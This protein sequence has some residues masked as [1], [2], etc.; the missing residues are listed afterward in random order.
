MKRIIALTMAMVMM[1]AMFAGCNTKPKD[2]PKT[3]DPKQ[4]VET[5]PEDIRLLAMSSTEKE[6]NVMRDQL[7]KAGFNVI[8]NIQPDYGSYTVVR[9]AGEYDLMITGWTTVTG[10][11]DYAV[12]SVFQTGGDYN[13]QPVEDKKIDEL[14]DKAGTETPEEYAN[15]YK[16]LEDVLVKENAY[17]IPMFSSLRIQ[18][19]DKAILD[20]SS[21]RQPKSRSN[22]WEK[23]SYVDT[24]LNATR[25]L[26][27]AQ[28]MSTLTS[29]WPIK[30]ND[31]SVNTLNT[32]IYV[33]L[34]N[35]TDE[36]DIEAAGSLSHNYAIG[37]GNETYYFL[38]RDDINF[39]KVEN[40]KAVDTGVRVGGE[41]VV[42]TL[43]NAK[44]K[45][46]APDHRTYTLHSSMEKI[47]VL[48]DVEELKTIKESGKTTTV[49][50]ALE[51]GAPAK[52]SSL[53]AAKTSVDNKAGKYQVIKITTNKPFPQVLNFLAHQSAGITCKEQV[54]KVNEGLDVAKYDPKTDV[55]YGDQSTVTEGPTYNNTLWMSGPYAMTY[56][57]DYEVAFEKNP[58][59]MVGTENEPKIQSI[60]YKFI[61]DN[62]STLSAFRA[63][64]IDM[65]GVIPEDKMSVIESDPKY[66]VQ[67][68]SSNGVSYAAFNLREG[69][70]F[71]DVD[72]RKAVMF[73]I[74][75]E[76]YIAVFNG[77]KNKCY[78]TV[79]TIID[80]GNELVQDLAQSNEHLA[81][82]QAKAAK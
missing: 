24:T 42:F 3:D 72:L 70:K 21:V 29:M 51:K 59:Y 22:P 62:D 39:S 19:I 57:N 56:K 50:E 25:P 36:D 52:V 73:A 53:E 30:S 2:D 40:K 61:K 41:D 32:N 48:T 9:D 38:L 20:V 58:A 75:Q 44:N 68:R 34:V 43:D 74:A 80:T 23:L 47:E 78:S 71:K 15:T 55:I 26:M 60:I 6:A 12:R 5:K 82:Y 67:K 35:L 54:M 37:E 66:T 16:E 13:S 76:D 65:M 63:G 18:A 33:R 17:I 10:N 46:A 27:M 79:S 49:L 8:L 14:I 4:T 77:L 81:A 1:L 64:E 7:T 69:S 45:D 11:P 31:G 28:T